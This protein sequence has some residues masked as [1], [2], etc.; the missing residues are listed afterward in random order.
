LA[1]LGNAA[2]IDTDPAEWNYGECRELTPEEI[3]EGR[4]AG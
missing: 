3:H 4:P 2:V 1:G